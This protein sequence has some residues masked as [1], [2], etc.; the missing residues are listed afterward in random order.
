MSAATHS[1]R[2]LAHHTRSGALR[3]AA[4]LCEREVVDGPVVVDFDLASGLYLAVVFVMAPPDGK[5][6]LATGELT[7]VYSVEG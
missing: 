7:A 3:A 4:D 1:K 6:I 5:T 2:I